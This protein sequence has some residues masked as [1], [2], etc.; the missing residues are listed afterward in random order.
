MSKQ[1]TLEEAGLK[2]CDLLDEFPALVNP[3]HS[4]KQGAKWQEQRMYSEEKVYSLLKECIKY[5]SAW[6]LESQNG[7][8]YANLKNWFEQVKKK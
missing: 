7:N 8:K 1:E 6:E 5:A 2:H 3:L 4:F